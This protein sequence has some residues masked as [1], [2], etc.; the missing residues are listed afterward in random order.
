MGK[1]KTYYWLRLKHDFFRQKEIKKL[2]Q[3]AGGD[4]YVIIYLKMQLLSLQDAGK[5]F[6]D[7][8]EDS[9]VNELALELDEDVDNVQVTFDFLKRHRLVEIISE[10]E[11]VLPETV[12]NIGSECDSAN[13]VRA[14]RENKKALQCNTNVTNSNTVVTLSNDAVTSSN[15]DIEID[16]DKDIELDLE[17]DKDFAFFWNSYPRKLDKER[18]YDEWLNVLERG[19]NKGNLIQSAINYATTVIGSSPQYIKHPKNFLADK[20]YIDYLPSVFKPEQKNIIPIQ[21]NYNKFNQYPQRS[22]T[23]E[24][25]A[26]IEKKLINKSI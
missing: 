11:L 10:D 25:Y 19:C 1:S 22:Y 16:I 18:A 23:A 5:L 3:I 4:T 6:F 26:E 13:R 15:T 8:V 9:F 14:H 20:S 12:K 17:K 21:R 2:R 24:D 7:G